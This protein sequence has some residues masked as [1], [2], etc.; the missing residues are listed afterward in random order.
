[1]TTAY[2]HLPLFDG[3]FTDE[4]QVEDNQR[5]GKG[6]WAMNKTGLE[7]K[8]FVLKPKGRTPYHRASKAAILAYANAIE[9]TNAQL[10]GELRNWIS[11]L[12]RRER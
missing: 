2:G 12:V 9:N 6:G 1:M 8:Y 3:G 4:N 5:R 11:D 10:A 7:L